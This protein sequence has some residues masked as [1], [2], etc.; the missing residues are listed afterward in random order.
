M[1]ILPENRARYP[2]DWPEISNRIRFERAGGRCECVGECGV[3]HETEDGGGP[4]ARCSRE[5]GTLWPRAGLTW[6]EAANNEYDYVKTILTVGHLDHDPSHCTDENLRAWC[7]GCHN[8]Y[9]RAHR[10]A[11]RAQQ[12][13]RLGQLTLLDGGVA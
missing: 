3:D 10:T 5:H 4:T 11:T 8:R 12:T 6:D 9:D 13:E 7:Q 1:P 2:A